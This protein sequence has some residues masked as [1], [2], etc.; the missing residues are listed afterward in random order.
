MEGINTSFINLIKVANTLHKLK[1]MTSHS[2]KL[3]LDLKFAFQIFFCN[4]EL[5]VILDPSWLKNF[6][7][8]SDSIDHLFWIMGVF[9]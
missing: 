3:C 4:L 7:L 5:I 8:W 2:K 9:V 6:A 1:G